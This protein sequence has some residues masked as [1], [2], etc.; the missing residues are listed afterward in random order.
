MKYKI[1][2]IVLG[3]VFAIYAIVKFNII[4]VYPEIVATNN[5]LSNYD[6]E[7][8]VAIKVEEYNI[9]KGI[10]TYFEDGELGNIK[11]YFYVVEIFF[12]TGFDDLNI[13]KYIVTVV[14][15]NGKVLDVDYGLL[16]T[17]SFD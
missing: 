7:N 10:Y 1:I 17:F 8:V 11:I 6:E 4:D 5:V 15:Q 9:Q 3:I 14:F 16:Q 12:Y 13:D 2:G